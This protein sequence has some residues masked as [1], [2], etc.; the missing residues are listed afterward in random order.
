[1]GKNSQ[2]DKKAALT[3][4]ALSL[5]PGIGQESVRLI[6]A[7][8]ERKKMPL[9]TFSVMSLRD[10]VAALPERCDGLAKRII[11]QTPAYRETAHHL[12]DE[13]I[14]SGGGYLGVTEPRYPNT[15][16]LHLDRHAP[17]LLFFKGNTGLLSKPSVAVVGTRRPSHKGK[18]AAQAMAHFAVT[19]QAVLVSGAAEGIDTAAHRAALEANGTTIAVLPQGLLTYAGPE[20]LERAVRDGAAL[21]LSPFPPDLPWK[22]YAAVTRN[23][24]IAAL[25]RLVFVVEPRKKGG[26]VRT[27]LLARQQ[28]KTVAVWHTEMGSFAKTLAAAGCINLNSSEN[29]I[30]DAELHRLW[31]QAKT[32]G[33]SEDILW[34]PLE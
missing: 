6:M 16:R 27:A 17:P 30:L 5:T 28:G 4:L 10:L 8:A 24:I 15:L 3:I 19:S 29:L 31:G 12:L 18:A 7:A 2:I 1:M 13:L 32:Q 33:P 21:L 14:A 23:A 26:S 11:E 20:Y 34:A 25:A 22:Q 9:P